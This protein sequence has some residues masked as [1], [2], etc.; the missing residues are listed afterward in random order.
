MNHPNRPDS[1]EEEWIREWLEEL[2]DYG[3]IKSYSMH[4]KSF[5]LCDKVDGTKITYRKT[6]SNK[7]E[8]VSIIREHYYTC[9]FKVKWHPDAYGVF[10]VNP[11][12]RNYTTNK[13]LLCDEN[14]ISY[15]EVKPIYDMQNMTMFFSLN[16]KWVYQ[17][18]GHIINLIIPTILNKPRSNIF[19]L[20]FTPSYLYDTLV[21]KRDTIKNKK[22]DT[23]FRY[24]IKTLNEFINEINTRNL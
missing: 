21:Y 16:R 11:I 19:Q 7:V 17:K 18:Y 8:K 15:I 23:K 1:D 12:D 20:T 4:P 2:Y 6:M 3:Y 10:C 13:Y 14:Y 5:L 24:K 22:G 9:D